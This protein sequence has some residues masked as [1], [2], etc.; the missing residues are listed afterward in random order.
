MPDS[1]GAGAGAGAGADACAGVAT[2]TAQALARRPGPMLGESLAPHLARAMWRDA[3]RE[4]GVGLPSDARRDVRSDARPDARRDARPD[5]SRVTSATPAAL[6]TALQSTLDAPLQRLAR[7]ALRRQ[8]AELRGREVEDGAVIVLD[9]ATGE[10]LAWV[11]SAGAGS[12]ANE[13]D[14][15]LA[16]RQP[17]ST[18]K[19]FVYALALER[20]L[21]TAASRIDDTP[22]QLAAGAAGL[23]APQNYD[24]AYRGGI[25]V[26]EALAGSVNVP[27]VRVAAMLGPEAL[28]E[29]LNAAG[30]RLAHS[31]GHHG[32]ALALGSADV[33]L[34]DLANAYRMLARG[35]LW[36]PVRW[37]MGLPG[38][39][40][41]EKEPSHATRRVF[42]PEAAWLVSNIL[43]DP[44]ARAASFGLDSPL[45]T[46]GHAAVKTGTSKDM[47]DNWC[48][49]S[50]E[51]HT[52]GVWVGNASGRPM[53]GVSGISGAAPVWREVAMAL[54]PS[55]APAPPPGLLARGDEWF[56]AG[57]E[58]PAVGAGRP[59][60][61]HAGRAGAFGIDSPREGTVIAFDPEIPPAAQRVVLRGAH[62]QWWLGGR[63]LGTG[64]R[65]EWQPR[66]GRHVLEWRE[67]AAG[68]AT[69]DAGREPSIERVAF[70]VRALPAKARA[71]PRRPG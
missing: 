16:R 8:L 15:V 52:I 65:V 14:A 45:V 55:R 22:L 69:S 23:Y 17:G 12:A 67:A 40:T 47:R 71:T 37:Q 43:A 33:T 62:G 30:L 25:S 53:H 42:A 34:L 4:G 36:S 9:N 29:R 57:T 38:M 51:R 64:T 54:G 39:G 41:P 5:A 6:P 24:H 44:A 19:P 60:A 26:R 28:F 1:A 59:D 48:V 58:P 35:G 7:A 56:L 2:V 11:G 50:T 49:G 66:P 32:H 31:A 20:R 10:V 3:Q 68:Q 61:A 27:A 63:L 46:R 18:I 70:E 13:V 21:A